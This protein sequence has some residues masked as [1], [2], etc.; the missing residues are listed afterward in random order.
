M[1]VV[2]NDLCSLF[3]CGQVLMI[4]G[5]NHLLGVV[6]VSLV[7]LCVCVCVLVRAALFAAVVVVVGV[8][9]EVRFLCLLYQVI[10]VI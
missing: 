1:I 6:I 4:V 7:F 9:C 3:L 2:V 10:F 5:V 8:S